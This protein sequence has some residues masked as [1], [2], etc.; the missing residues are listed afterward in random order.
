MW[1][2]GFFLCPPPLFFFPFFFLSA[3]FRFEI[4]V[5]PREMLQCLSGWGA[6]HMVGAE[7]GGHLC[8][9]TSWQ[10]NAHLWRGLGAGSEP[11]SL[12]LCQAQRRQRAQQVRQVEP[13][14]GS[15]RTRAD[16]Q[17][18]Q[19]P[20][21]A[22][23]AGNPPFSF[24]FFFWF[25]SLTTLGNIYNPRKRPLRLGG[26]REFVWRGICGVLCGGNLASALEKHF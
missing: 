11:R 25:N 3:S 23:R 14:W 9:C 2:P 22:H 26:N 21:L 18:I 8:A 24:F 20:S 6:G 15:C 17:S 16:I 12:R 1:G 4:P 10:V 13:G 19:G 5:T 7:R